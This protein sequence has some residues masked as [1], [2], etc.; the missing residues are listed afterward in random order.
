MK[1]I[2]ISHSSKDIQDTEKICQSIEEN[3]IPCWYSERDLDKSTNYW[4]DVLISNINSCKAMLLLVSKNS[5]SSEQVFNEISNAS[6]KGILIIPY[7]IDNIALPQK[8][9]YYLKKYEW[10]NAYSSDD[11]SAL[12][13]LFKKLSITKKQSKP[14]IAEI[15]IAN[16]LKNE[17]PCFD[18]IQNGGYG[19]GYDKCIISNGSTGWAPNQ[20]YIE[21]ID[22]DEF[23]FSSIGDLELE[24]KYNEFCQSAEYRKIEARGNNRTRW[25]VSDFYQNENL[26]ISLKKTKWSQTTF[27]WNQIR[28]NP[29][30]Q[31]EVAF[32][33]FYEQMPFYPN[34]LCMHLIIETADDLLIATKISRNKK[35]DY[36]YTIAVTIGEQINSNDFSSGKTNNNF[37]IYDWCKRALIEEFQF[38]NENYN[39]FID[40]SSIRILG[41]TY[42]GDIYN[43]A[44]PTYIRLNLT[45]DALLSYISSCSQS[46]DEYTEILKFNKDEIVDILKSSKMPDVEERF[47][48]SSFLRFLLYLNYKHPDILTK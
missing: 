37:F 44:L 5:I 38:T 8:Y 28:S 39:L 16:I 6:D 10:I 23:T 36:A 48:P 30:K 35:N 25:M 41:V 15:P 24:A 3:G 45:Y 22:C 40:E 26:Y 33:T 21:D 2:F 14:T 43:F 42:E 9:E 34:S 47:H 27:W 13:I 19:I 46:T 32:N 4:Q 11:E 7:F 17:N 31:Q 18:G 29:Q 1:K 20:I 12:N